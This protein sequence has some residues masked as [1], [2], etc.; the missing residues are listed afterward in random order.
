M[1]KVRGQMSGQSEQVNDNDEPN[2][3]CSSSALLLCSFNIYI[4]SDAILV[5]TLNLGGI[6][7]L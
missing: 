2:N 6:L 5:T 3:G 7:V 1:N 4:K